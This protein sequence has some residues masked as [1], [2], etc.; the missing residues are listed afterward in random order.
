MGL[1]ECQIDECTTFSKHSTKFPMR[2]KKPKIGVHPCLNVSS[3]SLLQSWITWWGGSCRNFR[4]YCY[5]P[6]RG[7]LPIHRLW[8][9]SWH[10][11]YLMEIN[12]YSDS[13]L[14]ILTFINRDIEWLVLK[15]ETANIHLTPCSVLVV[16]YCINL[17]G[18]KK[19]TFHLWSTLG[20]SFLHLFNENSRI[21]KRTL[22]C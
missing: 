5:P 20:M 8:L 10:P 19:N 7:C 16:R 9:S 15:G 3:T 1:S 13:M 11:W 17:R 4:I 22:Q 2:T 6:E 12:K 14:F 18:E 21:L